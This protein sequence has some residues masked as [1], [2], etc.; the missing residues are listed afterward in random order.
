MMMT[1]SPGLLVDGS[2]L[3][4]A[5]ERE[6]ALRVRVRNM[7]IGMPKRFLLLVRTGDLIRVRSAFVAVAER[8]TSTAVEFKSAHIQV[9]IY[10]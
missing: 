4:R 9:K 10:M 2:H 1:C 5:S 8:S 7:L 6:S 3:K